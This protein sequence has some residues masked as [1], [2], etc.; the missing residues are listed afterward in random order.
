MRILQ[1]LKQTL[2]KSIKSNKSNLDSWGQDSGEK[3]Q[4]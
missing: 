1:Q 4:V 3:S 2:F